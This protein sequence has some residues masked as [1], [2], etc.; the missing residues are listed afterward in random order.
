MQKKFL[1]K[2]HEASLVQFG[3]YPGARTIEELLH[4]GVVVIDKPAGP[5]SRMVDSFVKKI[6]NVDKPL[7]ILLLIFILFSVNIPSVTAISN[8]NAPYLRGSTYIAVVRVSDTVNKYGT[9]LLVNDLKKAVESKIIETENYFLRS[10]PSD[11]KLSFTHQ[12]FDANLNY[13][14]DYSLSK[15]TWIGDALKSLGYSDTNNDGSVIDEFSNSL[16]ASHSADNIV[17]VFV[18]AV[19]ADY[20][21]GALGYAFPSG[22][23]REYAVVYA[24]E[25][26]GIAAMGSAVYTH[27]IL[28]LFGTY[29]EYSKIYGG[30]GCNGGETSYWAQQ[31]MQTYYPNYNCETYLCS[32]KSIMQGGDFL[33]TIKDWFNI[34]TPMDFWSKGMVGWLD[35][36]MNGVP[37]AYDS[38]NIQF[39]N[40]APVKM[41]GIFDSDNIGIGLAKRKISFRN[42]KVVSYSVWNRNLNIGSLDKNDTVAMS[43]ISPNGNTIP[44]AN[45][46]LS[47]A[48]CN[49]VEV[50]AFLPIANTE[51]AKIP[52]LWKVQADYNLTSPVRV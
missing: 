44:S 4:N 36:D 37:D 40:H 45:V 16:H 30:S 12:F 3:K 51:N 49:D 42:P 43:F 11:A 47:G 41:T 46:Q 5:T 48:N 1:V 39:V 9:Y 24:Y 7:F 26:Y 2:S 32:Q 31:L 21:S 14:P 35:F 28:H 20:S 13:V 52:G 25:I 50:K 27:E 6:L 38:A 8:D 23:N 33:S 19:G 29:D 22:N 17:I 15:S 18:P 10:A 34:S